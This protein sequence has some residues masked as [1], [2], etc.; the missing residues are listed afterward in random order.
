MFKQTFKQ[1]RV[2]VLFSVAMMMAALQNAAAQ[3]FS[4]QSPQQRVVFRLAGFSTAR[5]V[6]VAGSFNDWKQRATPL[7]KGSSKNGSEWS[8]AVMLPPGAHAYKFIVDG[9][10]MTDPTNP[11]TVEGGYGH[12]NSLLILP[13]TTGSTEFVLKGYAKAKRVALAGSF[14]GWSPELHFFARQV[15]KDVKDTKDAK[16]DAE[17]VCRLNLRPGQYEYRF[18]VDG[19]WMKDSANPLV[20]PNEFHD[21]NSVLIVP[22]KD[23]NVEFSLKGYERAKAVALAGTFNGWSERRTMLYRQGNV[24][25][26]R[27]HLKPGTYQYKFVVDGQWI[28]DPA[29]K[30]VVENE[31]GTGNNLLTVK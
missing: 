5:E 30:L 8:V 12:K 21:V 29:N 11:E 6:F 20:V 22:S 14:N 3:P 23:G 13:S 17:W 16:A 15:V 25:T 27:I 26:C 28:L 9:E 7:S 18:V 31:Y 2:V 19:Q 24:W 10:W 1:R 4:Q